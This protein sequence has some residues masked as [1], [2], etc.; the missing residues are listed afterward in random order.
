MG[1]VFRNDRRTESKNGEGAEGRGGFENE[2]ERGRI[3]SS[4]EGGG[5]SVKKKRDIKKGRRG[6][7]RGRNQ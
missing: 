7:G 2:S 3:V 6:G 1:E 5:C 4:K